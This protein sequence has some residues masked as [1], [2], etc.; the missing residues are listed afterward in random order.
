MIAW[1]AKAACMSGT[2]QEHLA[3]PPP[4]ID[5]PTHASAV[6]A[7]EKQKVDMC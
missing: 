3:D 7:N 5:T 1:L 4:P 6:H 2:K